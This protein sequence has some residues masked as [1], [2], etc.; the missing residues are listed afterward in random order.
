MTETSI[1]TDKLKAIRP[2]LRIALLA[3]QVILPL[4]GYYALQAGHLGADLGHCGGLYHEYGGV[5]MARMKSEK[6][7]QQKKGPGTR[8][9][10]PQ[11]VVLVTGF[12]DPWLG[13]L[14]GVFGFET[15]NHSS[16]NLTGCP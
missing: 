10:W 15:A 6:K 14:A 13:R 4:A 9:V 2:K 12:N 1:K 8:A 16:R 5:D 7:Y 11:L 3:L